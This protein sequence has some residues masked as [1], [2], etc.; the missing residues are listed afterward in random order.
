MV[1]KAYKRS[2]NC[3]KSGK[4]FRTRIIKPEKKSGKNENKE[5]N[6]KYKILGNALFVFSSSFQL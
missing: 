1:R 3:R 4:K 2:K 5:Q 6:K